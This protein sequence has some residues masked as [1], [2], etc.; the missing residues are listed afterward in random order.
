MFLMI[1]G[2][3]KKVLGSKKSLKRHVRSVHESRD[4][5]KWPHLCSVC[6]CSFPRL[7]TLRKHEKKHDG[8]S[9][10]NRR[11]YDVNGVWHPQCKCRVQIYLSFSNKKLCFTSLLFFSFLISF[12]SSK[13]EI[14]AFRPCCQLLVSQFI[15]QSLFPANRSKDFLDFW[16]KV[17]P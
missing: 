1:W 9:S 17:R 5:N 11:H 2:S 16:H 13:G 4:E 12:K 14:M 3:Y 7:D 15:W 8:N 6:R 10:A